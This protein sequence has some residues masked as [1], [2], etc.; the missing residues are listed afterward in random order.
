MN[1]PA[2]ACTTSPAMP[3]PPIPRT[4]TCSMSSCSGRDSSS[5]PWA[6][7]AATCSGSAA[8]RSNIPTVSSRP[9]MALRLEGGV[10]ALRLGL[11]RQALVLGGVDVLGLV[12]QHDRDVV[13]DGVAALEARVVQRV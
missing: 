11:G 1:G 13:A 6:A 10:D 5:A 3:L 9:L 12:D 8:A 7:A 2:I 4:T